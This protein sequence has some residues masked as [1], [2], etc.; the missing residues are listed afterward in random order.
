[1]IDKQTE[2][3]IEMAVETEK[4]AAIRNRGE[5]HSHHEGWAILCEELQEIEECFMPFGRIVQENTESLWKH[6]RQ[7]E[8]FEDAALMA[9]EQLR[10]ATEEIVKECIQVMA[11]CDKWM[12]LVEKEH[13]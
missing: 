12:H 7:D 4:N 6:I 5:F 2:S 8:M 11:V 10:D 13:E 9:I 1:M 3:C